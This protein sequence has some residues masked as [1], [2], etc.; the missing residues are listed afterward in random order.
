MTTLSLTRATP[1]TVPAM[2]S[3]APQ[4]G[5]L[6]AEKQR[7]DIG[8]FLNGRMMVPGEKID[9]EIDSLTLRERTWLEIE[10]RQNVQVMHSVDYD[11]F[12][13]GGR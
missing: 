12:A 5:G 4:R 3:G 10:M 6:D 7:S 11:P 9:A 13:S 8:E 1:R 2:G